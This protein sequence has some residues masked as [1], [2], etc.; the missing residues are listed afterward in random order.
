MSLSV[1]SLG[2]RKQRVGTD[3]VEYVTVYA[4]SGGEVAES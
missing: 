2:V 1:P 3:K 4:W